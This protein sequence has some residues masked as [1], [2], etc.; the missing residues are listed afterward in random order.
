[1]V[2]GF[3]REKRIYICEERGI[4]SKEILKH[5]L[6]DCVRNRKERDRK[7]KRDHNEQDRIEDIDTEIQYEHSV[8]GSCCYRALL[9]IQS[10]FAS[11][12]SL[13]EEIAE[14]NNHVVHFLPKFHPELNP[15]EKLWCFSKRPIREAALQR[16]AQIATRHSSGITQQEPQIF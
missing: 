5:A 4:V 11:Q 10:D 1:M 14:E 7:E 2:N 16:A 13:L 8:D 3:A 6:L 12:K 9:S 15:I